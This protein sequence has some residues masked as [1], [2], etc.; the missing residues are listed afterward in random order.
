MKY[1]SVI[2]VLWSALGFSQQGDIDFELVVSNGPMVDM[3][4]L[5]TLYQ[6]YLLQ[7]PILMS[8]SIIPMQFYRM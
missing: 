2:I 8:R 3:Q 1:F 6:I 5:L 7:Q 4:M